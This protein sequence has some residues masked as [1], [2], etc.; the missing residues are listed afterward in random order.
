MHSIGQPLLDNKDTNPA[1]YKAARNAWPCNISKR[2]VCH[3]PETREIWSFG[4]LSFFHRS[5]FTL[6]WVWWQLLVGEEVLCVA[7]C[8]CA[9]P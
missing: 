4:R 5:L 8:R 3:F 7:H 2:A 1:Q 6:Q 9:G